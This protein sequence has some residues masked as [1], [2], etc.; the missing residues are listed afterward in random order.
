MA[1]F[2]GKVGFGVY[3]ETKPGVWMEQITEKS[4]YGDA[5]QIV[6]RQEPVEKVNDD[7]TLNDE[8]RIIADT[9]AYSH[10][11][12]IKYVELMGVKWKVTAVRVSRPRLILNIGKKWEEDEDGD[13][14]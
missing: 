11:G 4:Y 14:T 8:I 1:R 9:Y 10:Y 7:L 2:Y 13:Q 6:A 12:E 5:V 3:T